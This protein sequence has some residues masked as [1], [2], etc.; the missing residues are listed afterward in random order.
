LKLQDICGVQFLHGFPGILGA[1]YC[2]FICGFASEE[3]YG[4]NFPILF[5]QVYTRRRSSGQQA[6]LVF[7]T[8]IVVLA[9]SVISGY[10]TGLIIKYTNFEKLEFIF[11][12][13]EYWFIPQ[14]KAT[15][16][17]CSNQEISRIEPN[18][19]HVLEDIENW[20]CPEIKRNYLKNTKKLKFSSLKIRKNSRL[21]RSIYAR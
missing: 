16:I 21:F 5:P 12:D 10:L 11:D 17:N 6:G 2:A 20:T 4:E 9:I 8:L 13:E 14:S 15:S 18:K 1:I 7:A 19:N 3:K